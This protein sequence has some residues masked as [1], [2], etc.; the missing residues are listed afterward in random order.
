MKFSKIDASSSGSNTIVAAVAGKKIR[1]LS[2]VIIAAGA[3][4]AKWQSASTDLT[5][6][7]S[8][9]ANGG[10][11]PSVSVLAPGGVYGLFETA[12]G[13]ALNLNLGGAV[14]VSGHLTYIEVAV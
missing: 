6:A 4:T 11:A 12:S 8:L 9:A 5:G 2:Y 7:M 1:V 3:V 14:N 13:E 10:A